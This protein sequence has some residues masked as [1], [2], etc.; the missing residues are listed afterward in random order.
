QGCSG[1]IIGKVLHELNQAAGLG[2]SKTLY[3]ANREVYGLLRYGV[4]V[5]LEAGDQYFTVW[6]I[7]WAHPGNNDFATGMRGRAAERPRMRDT[8]E[9][10]HEGR[11]DEET[12]QSGDTT[13]PG[14]TA[15]AVSPIRRR[16]APGKPPA[17]ALSDMDAE[18]A[19]PERRR[20]KTNQIKQGMMQQLLTGRVRRVE[21]GRITD[22]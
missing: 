10:C 11:E 5:K 3:D 6:L 15:P 13:Q 22:A 9:R 8:A 1:K 18:I 16:S 7:D 20:D 2:G 17:T 21:S 19:A 4:K 14:D 12:R